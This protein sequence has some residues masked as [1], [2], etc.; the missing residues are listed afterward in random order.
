MSIQT[1]D[2]NKRIAKNTI[3]LSLRFIITASIGIYTSRVILKNLGIEDYGI[4][5]VVGGIIG[6]FSFL[7]SSLLN[8][9]QRYLNYFLGRKDKTALNNVYRTSINIFVIL[10][11]IILLLGETIGLYF[12]NSQLEIPGNRIIAANWIYQFALLS[13]F[14]NIIS[15]P[16]NALIIAFEKMKT[17]A[18]VA[19]VQSIAMLLITAV[20]VFSPI[21]KL[22]LYGLLVL[23]LQGIIR[24]FYGVYCK[25]EFPEI[26][27][28]FQW[29]KMLFREMSVF[30]GW[31]LTGTFA[32]M[33]L[34][35]GIAILI[36]VFFG[37]AINATLAIVQQVNMQLSTF[38]NNFQIASKPQITK[39][40]AEGNWDEMKKLVF[41][42]VKITFLIM[43]ILAIPVIQYVDY[44]LNLWL[45][46]VPPFCSIFLIIALL[47]TVFT[48][49]GA[50]IVTAIHST[51]TI[52][53]FQIADSLSF[54][55]VLPLTYIAYMI[56]K[57][58]YYAYIIYFIITIINI[59]I[60]LYFYKKQL[61]IYYSD[62][63]YLFFRLFV[64]GI[65]SAII[66]YFYSQLVGINAIVV[67]LCFCI[68]GFFVLIISLL[69][70]FDQV[71][72]KSIILF[73][74][75]KINRNN[76]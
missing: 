2:N 37:P 76:K 11:L 48:T 1:L 68:T 14:I 13:S 53:N 3:A 20:L 54:L 8:G 15:T 34:N 73:I 5:N 66:V 70:V 40:Y 64:A 16:Y 22:I 7:T 18:Y 9:T 35:Q 72:K 26:S 43:I 62:F 19:V 65:S 61:G 17:F 55:S 63:F 60:R 39:Y 75:N 38:A 42:T 47:N 58:A 52:R 10:G 32:F 51:G 59:L 4:Y 27:Y 29:D 71:E 33:M 25:K 24:I 21:D 36:N 30:S 41:L 12:I 23:L 67:I 28:K 44:I 74:Q 46:E 69:I 57:E 31:T 50:P 49:L 56:G 45:V 6:M